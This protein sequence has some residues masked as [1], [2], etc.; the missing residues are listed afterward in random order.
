MDFTQEQV[1]AIVREAVML[2]G[3]PRTSFSVRNWAV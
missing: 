1:D 3:R 2:P